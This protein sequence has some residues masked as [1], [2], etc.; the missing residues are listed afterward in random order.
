MKKKIKVDAKKEK[1]Q[2][3]KQSKQ[4]T[5]KFKQK[6]F[7]FY[8]DIKDYTRGKEDWWYQT[9]TPVISPKTNNKTKNKKIL[10]IL[11]FAVDKQ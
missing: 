5:E 6:Y 1:E 9:K 11:L 10:K 4:E 3:K 8:D 2:K 7:D